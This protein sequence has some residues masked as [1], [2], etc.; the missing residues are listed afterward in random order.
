MILVDINPKYDKIPKNMK[1]YEF[2]TSEI[3]GVPQCI[4][5]FNVFL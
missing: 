1:I 5:E 3:L 4:N 2:M